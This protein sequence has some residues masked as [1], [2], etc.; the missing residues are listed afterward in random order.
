MADTRD[1]RKAVIPAAGFGTRFLPITKAV[2]KEM[3][4]L[5]D[6]PAVEFVVREAA[7][8]GLD[9]VLLVTARGKA[10]IANYFDRALDVEHL[11][12]DLGEDERLRQVQELHGLATVHTVRQGQTLGLGH[13]V[14]MAEHHV[15][16]EPFAVLL[17][18]DLVDDRD[19]LLRRMVDLRSRKG[20][21]V[22]ALMEVPPE[23]IS[24][25][26]AVSFRATGDN[27]VVE[28]TDLVE[29]PR[30]DQAPSN[31]AVIGRYVLDPIV[32]DVL[33]ETRP[34]RGGEIQLT[35][36]LRTMA[37]VPRANGGGVH[38]V[39]FRGRRYDTGDKESYLRAFV[40]MA[41]DDPELGRAFG[42][43]LG[44][45]VVQRGLVGSDS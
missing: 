28:I 7:A 39:V 24:A 33:R 3:L 38:G 23:Q 44:S 43:W 27:D 40:S 20:G 29:K 22:V 5:V 10:A 4:P 25:Y 9:D 11:L 36:A 12:A 35:D 14:G 26:G 45:Y 32:F 13:A 8:A 42:Q 16:N 15:G 34:G 31:L 37:G 18:D 1:V 30:A 21:S 6:R 19:P 17:A 2:P 41:L